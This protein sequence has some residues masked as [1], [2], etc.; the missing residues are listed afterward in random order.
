MNEAIFGSFAS[1][2]KN[3][4]QKINWLYRNCKFVT[5]VDTQIILMDTL[6]IFCV[7]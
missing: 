4:I 6:V 7:C 3:E 1:R 5:K 2:Q